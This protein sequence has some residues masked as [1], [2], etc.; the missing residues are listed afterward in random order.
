MTEHK[1]FGRAIKWAYLMNWGEQGLSALLSFFLASILGPSDFGIVAMAMVYILFLQMFLD[2]GLV[3]ALIQRKDLALDHLDSV[4][5]MVLL[6]S[7]V[8]VGLSVG[9]SPWWGRANHLPKLAAVISILSITL[10][11]EALTVVQKALFQRNMDFRSLS[12]RSILS[13]IA[14]GIVGLTMGLKGYGPWALVGQRLTQDSAALIL[15]W[16]LSHWR[17]RFRFAVKD[18]RD[19]LGF[20]AAN[21][22]AK[23][24]VFANAQAESFFMGMFFGPFAV[25]LYR[26]AQR[27]VTMVIQITTSSLQVASFPHFSRLQDNAGE[28]R[29]SALLCLRMSSIVALPLM[30]GIAVSSR[31]IMGVIGTKWAQAVPVLAILS[32]AGAAASLLQFTGPLLQAKS[33]PHFLA[34][35]VW[36][37]AAVVVVTLVV[38]AILLR[39]SSIAAQVTGIAIAR[40]IIAFVFDLPV[41]LYF[42]SREA[43]VSIRDFLQV[44]WPSLAAAAGVACLA[45]LFNSQSFAQSLRPVFGL[46]ISVA[47]CAIA[48]GS[49][50]YLCDQEIRAWVR[51]TW[52]SMSAAGASSGRVTSES[53][54]GSQPPKP[55][56]SPVELETTDHAVSK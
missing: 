22:T 13:V 20:S 10:P 31:F 35:L 30:A 46:G 28:L 9:V 42:L 21:F 8:L 33:K 51:T 54:L 6:I 23:L 26:F 25:G 3:A 32:I 43:H 19:L 17:P 56:A 45:G 12:I 34:A 52:D 7:V 29:R 36:T 41:N 11:I 1:T 24:G 48:A 44:L 49:V 16:G 47:L 4:F 39:D 2:Q 14:G 53:G 15:L 55:G 5:W 27:L 50:L 40:L 38:T 18:I 37:N